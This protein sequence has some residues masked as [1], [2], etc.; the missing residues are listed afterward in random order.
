LLII[1]HPGMTLVAHLHYLPSASYFVAWLDQPRVVLEAH[2][3]FVKQTAAS[4]CYIRLADK[5][6]RL[7]V[8]VQH[9]PTKQ[10]VSEVRLC[11]RERWPDIHWRSLAS[12]YGKA[13]YFEYFADAFRA[14]IGRKHETLWA[15]NEELLTICRQLLQL[16]PQ[17]VRSETYHQAYPAGFIDVRGQ[18]VPPNGLPSGGPS[19]RQVFGSEFV[20]NLSIAD[21]LFCE[22]PHATSYLRQLQTWLNKRPERQVP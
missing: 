10:A 8:P 14:A 18:E 3:N 22:G 17:I 6:A 4:R 21:L 20:N 11:Y 13:P 19:Y 16:N 1:T 12:A 9:A 15:L 5:V 7:S 2:A